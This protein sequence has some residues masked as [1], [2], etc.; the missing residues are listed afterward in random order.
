MKTIKL[1]GMTLVIALTGTLFYSCGKGGDDELIE[2]DIR[3][4]MRVNNNKLRFFWDGNDYYARAPIKTSWFYISDFYGDYNKDVKT[5]DNW[6]HVEKG[7]GDIMGTQYI[8]SVDE[9]NSNEGRVGH[10]TFYQ[11]SDT[12]KL[13]RILTDLGHSPTAIINIVNKELS[14]E[15]VQ[16]GNGKY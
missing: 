11:L 5:S 14:I 16:D 10:I 7:E 13:R 2:E 8:V 15:I 3:V 6:I 9:N 4:E 12:E 1:I